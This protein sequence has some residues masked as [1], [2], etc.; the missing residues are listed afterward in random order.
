MTENAIVLAN[1]YLDEPHAKTTH[2]LVRKSERFTI[3][4]VIDAEHAGQDVGQLLDGKASGIPILDSTASALAQLDPRPDFCIVGIAT[5][6]G[7]LPQT[8]RADL[9]AA[10]EAGL[11]LVGGLHQCLGDDPE[12]VRLTGEHGG[13]ILDGRRPRPAGELR[14]W[15]G[16]VLDLPTPRIPVLGMDCAI[17]KRTTATLLFD[18]CR[19]AGLRAEMIY[20][21]QTGWMQ[22]FP[23]GFILDAT[24][25]D[26]VCGELEGAILACEREASPDLM[27]IEGQSGLR[28]PSGPCGAE[29]IVSTG[30]AGVVLQ[31]APGR[32]VF[33]DNPKLLPIPPV[34]EEIEL[35]RLL[36]SEVWAVTLH[37]D[38]L[39]P[40]E[41]RD[42]RD[43]LR[44]EL[45]LPVVLPLQEG[46]GEIVQRFRQHL[47]ERPS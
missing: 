4:A 22:G 26:F 12:L 36:G 30:A 8:V 39:T 7:V 32:R 28:N 5:A 9:I 1:G 2:A 16:E 25:N 11:S 13:K 42:H 3:R 43:R 38:G 37:E 34:A 27:L 6:G 33:K 45:G 31:H 18:A 15:T 21:G 47:A 40:G 17:G 41:A 14:F 44:G 46:V 35:I 23:Y 20:T 24:L 19:E 29:L 10:A